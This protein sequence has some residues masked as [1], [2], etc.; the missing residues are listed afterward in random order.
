LGQRIKVDVLESVLQ[1]DAR[2]RFAIHLPE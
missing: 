2:C 1:G